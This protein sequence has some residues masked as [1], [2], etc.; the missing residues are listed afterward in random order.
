MTRIGNRIF[1]WGERTFIMG[2]LNMT[3][4]SFSGD[5]VYFDTE[6]AVKKAREMVAEGADIID[7][8]GESTRPGAVEITS[9][10][11]IARV[12]P[13]IQRL[14]TEIDVPVSIDTFKAEV[15]E[16]AVKAG[17]SMLNDVWGLKRDPRLASVAARYNLPIV[18]T[19][20]QRDEPAK[21]IIPAIIADLGRAIDVAT[22]AKVPPRNIIVDPGFGF[23][24]T[25]SQN[26]EI[27]GRLD[28]F[29][30]LGKPILL[31]TS[32]KSTI[33][34][35]LGDVPAAERLFGTA[36]TNA[37]GIMNGADIIRV[38]D[39]KE[40]AQAAKMTDAVIRGFDD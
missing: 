38:H 31:G 5:G 6:A 37:I 3:P 26:L 32:R 11:E 28:E 35:V 39:V 20:S 4:D 2:I 12:I 36:A 34:K 40:N 1:H 27:L 29:K 25:V 19:S 15:A 22:K 18:L 23:G 30:I 17:A 7:V 21:D 14:S 24:K 8:G 13:I 16:A 9:E 10:E 33:G